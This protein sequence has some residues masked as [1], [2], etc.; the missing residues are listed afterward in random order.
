[1]KGIDENNYASFLFYDDR[2]I[3]QEFAV[4]ASTQAQ[5]WRILR[6]LPDSALEY[7][8]IHKERGA[9][10]LERMLTISIRHIIHHTGFIADKKKVLGIT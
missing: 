2:A 8:G 1:M 6:K 5:I 10:S 9:L 7:V 4:I 3:Y